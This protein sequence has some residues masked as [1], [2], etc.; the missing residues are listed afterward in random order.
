M[1]QINSCRAMARNER[2]ESTIELRQVD[3]VRARSARP[4]VESILDDKSLAMLLTAVKLE[5]V[6]PRF[7][8]VRAHTSTTKPAD[9]DG[10]LAAMPAVHQRLSAPPILGGEVRVE[11]SARE[12]I[13]DHLVKGYGTQSKSA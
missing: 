10:A 4:T 7:D 3:R 6:R 13:S 11:A 8:V 12:Q 5:N 9:P 2:L 1:V